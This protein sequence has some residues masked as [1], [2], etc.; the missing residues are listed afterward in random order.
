MKNPID[1]ITAEEDAVTID[2]VMSRTP[3]TIRDEDLVALVEAMRRDR[4]R[5]IVAEAK[6]AEKAEG[7]DDDARDPD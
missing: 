1:E 3:N 4:A 6:K 7:L 5:F 2:A